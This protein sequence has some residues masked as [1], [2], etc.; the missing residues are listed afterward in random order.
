MLYLNVKCLCDYSRQ[1]TSTATE[2]PKVSA[3]PKINEFRNK[4]E[5]FGAPTSKAIAARKPPIGASAAA[6]GSSGGTA[7]TAAAAGNDAMDKATKETRE[8]AEQLQQQL[9]Q[10][11]QSRST[12][13]QQLVE[14]LELRD[15]DF[16]TINEK[17][18][19]V[20]R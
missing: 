19:A 5:K 14:K 12:E 13:R 3:P 8:M 2:D 20:S 1:A 4:F 9:T 16:K 11:E 15:A 18:A 10:L 17:N 6:G 7:A